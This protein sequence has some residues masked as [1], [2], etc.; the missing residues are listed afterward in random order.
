MNRR[1]RA[2]LVLLAVYYGLVVTVSGLLHDHRGSC[3]VCWH[4]PCAAAHDDSLHSTH[5][6]HSVHPGLP[7]QQP[8]PQRCPTDERHCVA[9]QF[10]AQK[11]LP[12]RP[13]AEVLSVAL[14]QEVVLAKLPHSVA[15][16]STSWHS[17][18]PP[19]IS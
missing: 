1:N 7:A 9:C 12:A 8:S 15:I 19:D 16:V 6:D 13:I 11:T 17:R 4:M 10:L 14:V 2:I 5:G 18:A 3:D